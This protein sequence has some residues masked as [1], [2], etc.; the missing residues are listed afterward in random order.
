[1][2][3]WFDLEPFDEDFFDTAPCRSS[4]VIELP[5]PPEQVW[6]GFTASPPLAWCRV[7]DRARYT[8]ERPYGVGTTRAVR[9]GK[10]LISL[11]ERFFRWEEGRRMSFYVTQATMPM[12][13]R[14]GEDYLVEKTA[15]GSRFTWG[16]AYQPG[17][18]LA[19]TGP[20]GRGFNTM[21]ERGLVKDTERH[22][23]A[24]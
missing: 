16:F 1:M 10:G 3:R 17:T 19:A 22:F 14:F 7:L 9:V 13:R 18:L 12:F 5:V 4:Y 11:R 2:A 6:E 20:L 15:A 8:S 24:R 21:L 23:G